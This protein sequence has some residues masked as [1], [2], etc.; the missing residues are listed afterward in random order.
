[1][2]KIKE[3]MERKKEKKTHTYIP[4]ISSSTSLLGIKDSFLS[5]LEILLISVVYNMHYYVTVWQMMYSSLTFILYCNNG[6]AI[7][8]G[9]Q[10]MKSI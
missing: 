6:F 9:F 5:K 3:N 10:L 2:R 8:T 7:Y 1:M 4:T